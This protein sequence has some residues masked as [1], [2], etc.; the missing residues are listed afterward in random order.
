MS[1][2]LG[3]FPNDLKLSTVIPIHKK[4][5]T[6]LVENYRPITIPS[7]FSKLFEKIIHNRMYS[8]INTKNI[9]SNTQHGFRPNLST[10]TASFSLI[11]C[12]YEAVDKGDY[13]LTLFFDLTRAFDCV[14]K[15]F[16]I[17]KLNN[18][19]I[20]QPLNDW[21][22]SFLSERKI[23]VKIG[24]ST[25]LA[26]QV[27][28][29]VPQGGVLS[30]LLFILFINDLQHFITKNVTLVLYADDTTICITASSPEELQTK[31]NRTLEQF[32]TWCFNNKL[33]INADKTKYIM[34]HK[35]RANPI[36]S[37]EINNQKVEKT[38]N[39]K[40]LG[41]FIDEQLTWINHIEYVVK[42]LNS[43]YFAI[44]NL[45]NVMDKKYL[46]NIYFA[47]VYPHMKYL[48]IYWGTSCE[49][50][51]AFVIQKKIIRLIFSLNPLETCRPTFI[52]SKIFSLPCLLIHEAALFVKTNSDKFPQHNSVHSHNTRGRDHIYINN[53][54][55]STYKKGPYY[56]CGTIFNKL[57][58]NIKQQANI[59]KFKKELQLF[60][61]ENCFYSLQEF[62]EH[63][64]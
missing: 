22:Y 17:K 27:N 39:T 26:T 43:A 60:L 50:Q 5:E 46:L 19:G 34:F 15:D 4:G 53:F 51:R 10:N 9:L 49:F 62:Y 45:R 25:S 1:V 11:N 54:H 58:N 24:Q 7:C 42:K 30:P 21:I 61:R 64:S 36:I 12:I 14:N 48:I 18:L 31:V 33:I 52:K 13:V 16:I 23:S 38:Q 28:F 35:R 59:K 44:R 37:V 20:R 63:A 55:L 32:Y 41:L 47:L 40:F 2:K 6:D 8:F 57:P 3:I 56:T 29:G